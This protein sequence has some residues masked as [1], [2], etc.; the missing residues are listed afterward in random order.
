VIAGTHDVVIS[1]SG[2]WAK[3]LARRDVWKIVLERSWG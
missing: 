1:E 2:H 3:N